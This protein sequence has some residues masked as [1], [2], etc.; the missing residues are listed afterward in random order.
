[1]TQVEKAEAILK[2]RGYAQ[3]RIRHHGD[4][5][6]IEVETSDFDKIINERTELVAT[7][8]ATGYRFV[9]LDL[10][11]YSMGSSA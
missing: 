4:L 2:A 3:Y 11:G 1:M 7:I 10:A 9:S 8:K 5:C 6:R